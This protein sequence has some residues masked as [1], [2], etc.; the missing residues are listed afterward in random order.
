MVY[1]GMLIQMWDYLNKKSLRSRFFSLNP[2]DKHS[3]APRCLS[4]MRNCLSLLRPAAK[5][6]A[7]SRLITVSGEAEENVALITTGY[8]LLPSAHLH[9]PYLDAPASPQRIPEHLSPNILL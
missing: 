3:L 1:G 6:L 9:K 7:G 2:I 5:E 4:L 8:T